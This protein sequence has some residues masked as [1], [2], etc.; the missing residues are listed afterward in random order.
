MTIIFVLLG[1][2][3]LGG[4]GFLIAEGWPYLVLER[5]F[6]Q[7]IA[8]TVLASAGAIMLALSVVLAELRRTRA[9]LSNALVAASLAAAAT[10]EEPALAEAFAL[11]PAHRREP[12]GPGPL[13]GAAAGIALGTA[14][15]IVLTRGGAASEA[16]DGTADER[17]LF[18]D[19]AA[20]EPDPVQA[21]GEPAAAPDL[22]DGTA[23]LPFDDPAWLDRA[24]I[25]GPAPTAPDDARSQT[26]TD[27]PEQDRLDDD[28]TRDL[29]RALGAEP[30]APE[31]VKAQA[32]EFDFLRER[33]SHLR[34]EP[35]AAEPASA[36]EGESDAAAWMTPWR[37]SGETA[38]GPSGP[39]H[40]HAMPA[41]DETSEATPAQDWPPA[42]DPAPASGT[43][44]P[45]ALWD[46]PEPE[47]DAPV[48]TPTD[49][50]AAEP[51]SPAAAD[52]PAAGPATEALPAASDEGI[53][54]AYQVGD[55][56]FTI[57]AD[58]SI[59]AR[60]PDGDYGFASM[61][62]LKAYLASEKSRLGV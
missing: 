61:D 25:D 47:A 22:D 6:T 36:G 40:D 41:P 46:G 49:E 11:E 1:L 48:A 54:G 43:D 29:E 55:A 52:E 44:M 56:H 62:E 2:G 16:G 51:G 31:P 4:G 35:E 15:G 42:A 20:P 21:T 27:T 59:K 9:T 60:T 12:A 53:V 30:L 26:A 45:A 58:G 17:D 13:A 8:G 34:V 23:S 5:G 37:D 50:T 10:R 3:L 19:V 33:L 14:A 24:P 7:V 57:F 39:V 38:P 28:F 32:S 18:G